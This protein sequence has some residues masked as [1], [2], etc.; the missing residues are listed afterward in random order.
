MARRRRYA[1]NESGERFS[2]ILL[3]QEGI[4]NNIDHEVVC[5]QFAANFLVPKNIFLAEWRTRKEEYGKLSI[6][7]KVSELTIYRIAFTYGVIS[8]PIYH[9]LVEAFY[10]KFW[11]Q[12]KEEKIGR[13]FL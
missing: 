5:N 6:L 13:R 1:H 2:H 3:G 11:A 7:F 9:S 12:K 10:K 4:T 8:E